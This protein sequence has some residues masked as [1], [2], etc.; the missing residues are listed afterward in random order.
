MHCRMRVSEVAK[1]VHCRMRVKS[2]VAKT[3]HCR[4]RVSEVAKRRDDHPRMATKPR[5]SDVS[6]GGG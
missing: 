4:M 2:E 1:T 3:E 6:G 5:V